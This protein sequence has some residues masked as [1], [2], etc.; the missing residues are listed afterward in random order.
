MLLRFCVFRYNV[1]QVITMLEEDDSFVDAS[2][3]QNL[4]GDGMDSDEDSDTEEG[5]SANHLNSRQLTAPAEFVINYCSDINSL[6]EDI[7]DNDTK[8]EEQHQGLERMVPSGPAVHRMLNGSGKSRVCLSK[9]SQLSLLKRTF[10]KPLTPMALSNAFLHD[11]CLEY[12]AKMTNLYAQREKGK[13]S[14]YTDV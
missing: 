7:D 14:F 12:V 3:Y 8:Q 5:C 4:P 10:T 11:E 9:V 6:K 2:V 13:H 1:N